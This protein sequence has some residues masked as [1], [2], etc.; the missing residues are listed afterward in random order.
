MI[1]MKGIDHHKHPWGADSSSPCQCLSFVDKLVT[2]LK[3]KSKW[4]AVSCEWMVKKRRL[5]WLDHRMYIYSLVYLSTCKYLLS[6]HMS[7]ESCLVS[8]GK[9]RIDGFFESLDC[10]HCGM[11]PWIHGYTPPEIIIEVE[12]YLF[13]EKNC[14]PAG[15]F[16]LPWIFQCTYSYQL[17]DKE[18]KRSPSSSSHMSSLLWLVL[19]I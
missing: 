6:R 12:N 19:A 8:V 17:D 7:V 9:D 14:H 18:E 5:V 10:L 13:V 3:L 16:P 11:G 15:P 1:Q 4:S 2:S